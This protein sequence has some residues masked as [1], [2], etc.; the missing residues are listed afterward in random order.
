MANRRY[1]IMSRV[2]GTPMLAEP[3]WLTSLGRALRSEAAFDFFDEDDAPE[4]EIVGR[5][6]IVPVRGGLAQRGG[7]FSQG[8]DEIRAS[9]DRALADETVMGIMLDI[10]SP[11]GEASGN[12]AFVDYLASLR[13]GDT[14][15]WAHVNEQA[16]SAAYNIAAATSRVTA[17]ESA[18]V[19]SIGVVLAHESYEGALAQAGIKVTYVHA[20]EHKVDGNPAEDLTPEV[21]AEIQKRVDALHDGFVSR[22]AA[23]RNVAEAAVRNTEARIYTASDALDLGLVDA[24]MDSD[25]ALE[26]FVN[27]LTGAADMAGQTDKAAEAAQKPVETPQASTAPLTQADVDRAVASAL[28][29]HTAKLAAVAALPGAAERPVL[30]QKLLAAGLGVEQIGDILATAPSEAKTVAPA[31]KAPEPDALG[32]AMTATDSTN[33]DVAASLAPEG[34]NGFDAAAI[35][36]DWRASTNV[37]AHRAAASDPRV[38]N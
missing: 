4:T 18:E 21:H 35:V 12:F 9:I 22:V 3:V 25:A 1:R 34:G 29:S 31:P 23:N 38:I 37:P 11:G 6:A 10:D 20:G 30:T 36:A 28:A 27:H 17:T 5:V 32:A 15:I 8:Y 33:D 26:A 14:P 16:T 19:G 2:F 13:D 24:V 7:W